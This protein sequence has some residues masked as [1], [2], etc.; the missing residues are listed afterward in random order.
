MLGKRMQDYSS[1]LDT[2]VSIYLAQEKKSHQIA[3]AL[4]TESTF[5]N[6]PTMLVQK[7]FLVETWL[8]SLY[9]EHH[10]TPQN[11]PQLPKFTEPLKWGALPLKGCEL[12]RLC[13]CL[14][15]F[16][17]EQ[18]RPSLSHR[19]RT[20]AGRLESPRPLMQLWEP[21]PRTI[22]KQLRSRIT[23]LTHVVLL[24]H[25]SSLSIFLA[26][27]K[28]SI[29]MLNYIVNYWCALSSC[30]SNFQLVCHNIY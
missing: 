27:S 23:L 26:H 25:T 12:H 21:P 16:N 10:G 5:R 11:S 18:L 28:R 4:K 30:N 19:M 20:C 7:L 9:P 6:L 17:M 24:A 29:S 2:N 22:T 3:G 1:K 15:Y 14:R 8:P 13:L